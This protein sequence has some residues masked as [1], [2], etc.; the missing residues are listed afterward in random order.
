M[1]AFLAQVVDRIEHP[2]ARDT[3]AAWLAAQLEASRP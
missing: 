2:G 3:A 1:G